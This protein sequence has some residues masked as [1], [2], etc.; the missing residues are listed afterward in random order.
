MTLKIAVTGGSGFIGRAVLAALAEYDVEAISLQRS[1]APNPNVEIRHFDLSA[2]D[3]QALA[4]IDIIIHAAAL[5]HKQNAD[6]DAHRVLNYAASQTLI[7]AARMQGVQKFIFISTVGVYGLVSSKDILT[8]TSP[9]NPQTPYAKAKLKAEDYLLENAGAMKVSIMRLPL[10]YG[11]NA[12]GN[13]G[14]LERLAK[15]NVPLP[16]GGIDNQRSMVDVA[17]AAKVIAHIAVNAEAH[18]GVQLLADQKP[19]STQDIIQRIRKH[20]N[21]PLW[22]VVIPKSWMRALLTLLGKE[23]L[24]QQLYEDLIFESSI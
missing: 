6:D 17:Y 22:L 9:T 12:P 23:A 14:A 20:Y 13:Y 8:V 16:F 24:Y 5:V 3:P 1:A 19:Y 11:E 21:M 15:K 7:D 18:L 4:D 10:V 2:I